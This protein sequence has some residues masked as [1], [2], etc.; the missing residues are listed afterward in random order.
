[1][2]CIR[3][4][5]PKHPGGPAARRSALNSVPLSRDGTPPVSTAS[6]GGHG[7]LASVVCDGAWVDRGKEEPGPGWLRELPVVSMF[8]IHSIALHVCDMTALL[9][10]AMLPLKCRY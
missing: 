10:R 2:P 6:A 9:R 1:M 4:G 3:G 8:G 5:P 7:G